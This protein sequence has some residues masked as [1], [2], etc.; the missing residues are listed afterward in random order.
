MIKEIFDIE[1]IQKNI[2]LVFLGMLCISFLQLYLFKSTIFQSGVFVTIG[3]SLALALCWSLLN[4][5]PLMFF[6]QYAN[7]PEGIN[8][9]DTNPMM[10]KVIFSI[11]A[12]GIAWVIILTYISYE[13]SL[14][15][16]NLIRISIIVAII[17]SI[18]WLALDFF[19]SKDKI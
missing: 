17:R 11:G 14:S 15:F 10:D 8:E 12:I 7:K 18:F 5:L 4:L 16:K 2:L 9:N 19:S 1:P 6:Y 13:M 3:I